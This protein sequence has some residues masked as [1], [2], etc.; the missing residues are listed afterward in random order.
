MI[1]TAITG[2]TVIITTTSMVSGPRCDHWPAGILGLL[3]VAR[4]F[5]RRALCVADNP[6]D[7]HATDITFT[8]PETPP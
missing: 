7:Q 6:D 2:S 8:S 5:A 1:N 3:G 4:T